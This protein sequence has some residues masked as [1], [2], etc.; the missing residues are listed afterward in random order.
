MD[1]IYLISHDWY[2]DSLD[3]NFFASSLEDIQKLIK[4]DIRKWYDIEG[5]QASIDFTSFSISASKLTKNVFNACIYYT[6]TDI[7]G[8]QWEKK[9]DYVVFALTNIA[10]T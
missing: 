6:K 7:Y 8:S 4:H 9:R 1:T 5:S 10:S 3:T 2:K